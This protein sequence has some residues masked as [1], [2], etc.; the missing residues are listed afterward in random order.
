M[1]IVKTVADSAVTHYPVAI[2]PSDLNP[3]GTIFGGKIL[4]EL[5]RLAGY[6]A[7]RHSNT[8]CVTLGV[9]SVRFLAPA[10]QG[11]VLIFK[12]TINRVWRTSLEV[13]VKVLAENLLTKESRHVVSAYLT[14]VAVDELGKPTE[15]LVDLKP[16]TVDEKRRY[17]AA[18]VR[19]QQRLANERR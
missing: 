16:E 10:R 19:R 7:C 8:L 1:R 4:S 3:H 18:E 12:A 9:D 11:E 13:G 15:I 2:F 6:V 5:D 14:F 17:E